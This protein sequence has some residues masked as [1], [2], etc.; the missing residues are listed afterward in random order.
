MSCGKAAWDYSISY[1]FLFF[2]FLSL[3]L[4]PS[5]E[6]LPSKQLIVFLS[7]LFSFPIILSVLFHVTS[8]LRMSSF[9]LTYSVDYTY[10]EQPSDIH[11]TLPMLL[12]PKFVLALN[13]TRSC[14]FSPFFF[15]F[16]FLFLCITFPNSTV[17]TKIL[18]SF[19]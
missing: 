15:L 7:T 13:T 17:S 16:L 6:F 19:C 9:I 5:S 3:L 18:D 11:F 14:R 12:T 8:T 4:T 2:F 1:F 10:I